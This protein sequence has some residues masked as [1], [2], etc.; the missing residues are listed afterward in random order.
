MFDYIRRHGDAF[1]I[2]LGD[3]G[4]RYSVLQ[5]TM[6]LITRFNPDAM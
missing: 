2:M 3:A 6:A 1:A 4:S 5:Q